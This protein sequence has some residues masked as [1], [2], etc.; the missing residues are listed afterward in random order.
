VSDFAN[1]KNRHQK[2]FELT[3]PKTP[4]QIK[5]EALN[6]LMP[7]LRRNCSRDVRLKKLVGAKWLFGV[8][9]DNSF[10]NKFGGDG[11]GRVY[12]S[13]KDLRRLYGHDEDTL[14]NWRNKLCETGWI[15]F[16]DRWPKSC[17][18]IVGAC[19]QPELPFVG[20]EF[21]E[22]M[23]QT[24]SRTQPSAAVGQ[25]LNGKTVEFRQNDRTKPLDQ[26]PSAVE[27]T[28]SD[29]LNNRSVRLLQPPAAA[30][31]T[32]VEGSHQ[33]PETVILTEMNGHSDPLM[34]VKPTESD[35][36][37]REI[38]VVGRLENGEKGEPLPTE[39]QFQDWLK[40]LK[41]MYTSRLK[42]LEKTFT[43][44]LALAKSHE[45]KKEWKRRLNIVQERLLGGPVE[46]Q[47]VK[48]VR[49]EP[50]PAMT[51]EQQKAAWEKA[52]EN[53]PK[54]KAAEKAAART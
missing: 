46:D 28:E 4:E 52:K 17:W 15:W 50:K 54:Q 36:H 7:Q 27:Q 47:Q 53:L 34:T 25:E 10:M 18:G 9:T 21:T 26:P 13:L 39:E 31:V 49:V 29:G 1:E 38:P 41:G 32:G 8:L 3:Q 16:Q 42:D 44:K 5:R 30:S 37:I 6:A 35:G 23:A 11:N 2:A 19:N 48:P 51:F 24:S 43:K 40:S 12:C 14:A 45:A 20:S 22:I 33:P